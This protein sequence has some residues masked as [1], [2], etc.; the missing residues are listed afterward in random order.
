VPGEVSHGGGGADAGAGSQEE[1]GKSRRYVLDM[2]ARLHFSAKTFTANV[3]DIKTAEMDKWL[4]SMKKNTSRTKKTTCPER[5]RPKRNSPPATTWGVRIFCSY[6]E[7]VMEDAA[8]K[9][10]A[11]MPEKE[12]LKEIRAAI[13]DGL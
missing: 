4:A 8:K 6:R 2:Q 5:R 11:I 12:R 9:Q 13:A 1:V 3:A 10:L 7:R